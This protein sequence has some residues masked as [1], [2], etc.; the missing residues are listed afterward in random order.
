MTCNIITYSCVLVIT[1]LVYSLVDL[2]NGFHLANADLLTVMSL[3][4][5]EC[6]PFS[7]LVCPLVSKNGDENNNNNNIIIII[8]F[9]KCSI[10][11]EWFFICILSHSL[12]LHLYFNSHNATHGVGFWW[13]EENQRSRRKTLERE[14]IHYKQTQFTYHPDRLRD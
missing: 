12:P 13:R 4:L 7:S 8:I 5:C 6:F 2:L 9:F 3:I 11:T 10:S 1:C 14:T